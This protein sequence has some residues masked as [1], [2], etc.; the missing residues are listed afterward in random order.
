MFTSTRD[1]YIENHKLGKL[2]TKE[3]IT[4]LG[5]AA[6]PPFLFLYTAGL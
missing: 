6:S 2:L 4:G 1:I 3:L 5:P